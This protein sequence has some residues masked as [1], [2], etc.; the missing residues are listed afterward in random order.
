MTA[1]ATVTPYT[2]KLEASVTRTR[3]E[4]EKLAPAATLVGSVP[5]L[6]MFAGAATVTVA[7]PARLHAVRIKGVRTGDIRP[8]KT[9]TFIQPLCR[10]SIAISRSERL[11]MG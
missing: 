1:K 9:R 7:E 6:V 10:V 8:T 2:G 4:S 5:T 11:G 3:I